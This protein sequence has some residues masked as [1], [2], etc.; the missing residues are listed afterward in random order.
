VVSGD[1]QPRDAFYLPTDALAQWMLAEHEAGRPPWPLFRSLRH[2]DDHCGN[3]AE[4]RSFETV[5]A[6]L[7]ENS[8]LHNDD[9]TLLR[10]EVA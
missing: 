9:T 1:W 10:V 5:V 8:G 2:A 7:R 4:P 3:G 6:D